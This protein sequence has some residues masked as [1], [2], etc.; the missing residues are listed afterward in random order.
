MGNFLCA[1]VLRVILVDLAFDVEGF[2]LVIRRCLVL[3]QLL[4]LPLVV[5]LPVA[6]GVT[7]YSAFLSAFSTTLG[8]FHFSFAFFGSFDIFLLFALVDIIVVIASFLSLL[9]CF[10]F[11][12]ARNLSQSSFLFDAGLL[13]GSFFCKFG[14]SGLLALSVVVFGLFLFIPVLNVVQDLLLVD[15]RHA[16]VLGE[17]LSVERL[18]TARLARDGDLKWLEAALLAELLLDPLD[19]CSETAL[20]VPLEAT[21]VP[22]SF[23]AFAFAVF[24]CAT[25][26]RHEDL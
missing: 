1:L 13:C 7:V 20:A 22:S 16:V 10:F 19:V 8:G 24:S 18:A 3:S 21:I 6:L 23:L 26:I 25:L 9:P 17:L 5:F 11:L 15:V 4:Q 2:E 14:Q 12:F